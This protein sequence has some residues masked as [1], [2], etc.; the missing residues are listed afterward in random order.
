MFFM[1]KIH[2]ANISSATRMLHTPYPIAD[3]YNALS[4]PVYHAVAYEFDTAAQME[5]AFT[6]KTPEHTYSRI[7]NPTV[8]YFEQRV[9]T[10]T[11]ARDVI[12]LNSGMAAIANTFLAIASAGSN[13][14]T[15]PHLFG[16]TYS[17][18]AFTLSD[19]GVETRFCDLT[20]LDNVKANIDKN[21]R[22]VYLEAITNPQMEVADLQA[23][24][25]ICKKQGVPLIADTTI[26]PFTSFN[27]ADFGVDIEVISSTKYISGG[28]TSLGGLILDFGTFDWQHSPKLR[29]LSGLPISAFSIKIRK[30]IHRNIGACMTP[31]TAQT[32]TIGLETLSL[33]YHRAATTCRMLAEKMQTLKGV[34]AVNY[35]SLPGNPYYAISRKQFGDTSGAMFTFDLPSR[36]AAFNFIDRLQLIRRATNLFDNKTLAIHPASTIF[37]SFTED[38]RQSMHISQR[39]LRISVGLEDADDLFDDMAQALAG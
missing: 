23:L 35:P 24:S 36:E 10:F 5:A 28:A 13:I 18:L 26:V 30:E 33:R 34:D 31:Q 15:S 12:A 2:S 3:A 7:T 17:L 32:Q 8:Q 39:T 14:V 4:M 20:N 29:P 21:T 22:A 27:A 16:N 6:G 19:F 1:K 37:G 38:I 9:K 25:D 11:K